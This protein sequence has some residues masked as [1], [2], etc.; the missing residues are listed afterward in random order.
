[1]QRLPLCGRSILVVEDQPLIAMDIKLI[2]EMAG[3]DVTTTDTLRGAPALV[4]HRPVSAV[5]LDHALPDGEATVLYAR[6]KDLGVPF[7]IYSGHQPIKG[8]WGS[9]PHLAKPATAEALVASMSDLI[10]A[11]RGHPDAR[12]LT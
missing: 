5:I 11:D 4:Q 8:D 10:W 6:L 9:A 3:A 7:M 12:V 2:F 1:M